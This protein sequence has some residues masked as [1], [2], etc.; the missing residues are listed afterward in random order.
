LGVPVFACK[1]HQFPDL[2]A[3][4]LK[5]DDILAWAAEAD[6]KAIRADA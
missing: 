5:R 6:V 1:P 2:M 4:A 3:A